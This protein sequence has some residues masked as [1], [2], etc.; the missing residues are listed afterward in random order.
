MERASEAGH[1]NLLHV[2]VNYHNE[3]EVAAFAHSQVL[4]ALSNQ[5]SFTIVDNASDDD[6][7]LRQL[8][9]DN[10]HVHLLK[11]GK[12]LGYLGAA[13]AAL[14]DWKTKNEGYPEIFIL[15]NTD[16]D[17]LDREPY[18]AIFKS[19]KALNWAMM[20]PAIIS[21]ATEKHQN[22]YLPERP[23]VRK[24]NWLCKLTAS[25]LY[26]RLLMAY[27]LTKQWWLPQISDIPEKP[28]QVYGVHG[29]F[30]CLSQKYFEA[31]GTL[32]FPGFLF[33]E[34]IFLAET[35]RLKNLPVYF[36]PQI[37]VLHSEHATTGWIKSN[38]QLGFMHQS[39]RYLLAEYFRGKG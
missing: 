20:G 32:D 4:P 36:D 18:Q 22:P 27:H 8:A 17:F 29:S 31:G 19:Y 13:K 23:S 38:K 12:N 5:G 28:T 14:E 33:G 7:V 11:P 10:N 21:T 39:Y 9:S 25:P 35:C 24:M 34:E 6:E 3:G 30:L 2:V 1:L 37:Q 16:I 26:Y 15:S